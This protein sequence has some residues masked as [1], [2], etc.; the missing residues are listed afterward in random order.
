M[1]Y[2]KFV[3]KDALLHIPGFMCSSSTPIPRSHKSVPFIFA[4]FLSSLLFAWGSSVL[5]NIKTRFWPSLYGQLA[6]MLEHDLRMKFEM[7]TLTSELYHLEKN[8]TVKKNM[9]KVHVLL[10]VSFA[11][12]IWN[13]QFRIPGPKEYLC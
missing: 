4:R 10:K 11:Q 6:N 8:K 2:T 9:L 13:E 3:F 7:C 12:K 1:A 5:V